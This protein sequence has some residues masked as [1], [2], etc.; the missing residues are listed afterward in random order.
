MPYQFSSPLLASEA[1]NAN[2]IGLQT[3]FKGEGESNTESRE[4]A[5]EEERG[6]ERSSVDDSSHNS[7]PCRRSCSIV[8]ADYIHVILF[9]LEIT[10]SQAVHPLLYPCTTSA[11]LLLLFLLFLSLAVCCLLYSLFFHSSHSRQLRH[12]TFIQ[13]NVACLFFIVQTHKHTH[14]HIYAHT[15]ASFYGPSLR[16]TTTI[17]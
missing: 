16:F 12:F 8:A 15:L 7:L 6:R 9:K 3:S 1:S 13:K 2:E 11:P 14:T 17:S 10:K 4:R 5:R